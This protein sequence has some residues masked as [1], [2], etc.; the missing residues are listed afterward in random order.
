MDCRNLKG[1]E[2]IKRWKQGENLEVA[3]ESKEYSNSLHLTSE[4]RGISEN[5]AGSG[6]S[7]QGG[8]VIKME[9]GFSR[10]RG[11]PHGV[12]SCYSGVGGLRGM[13]K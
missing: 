3:R 1:G 12:F 13:R 7:N 11:K 2:V 4:Q 10:A 9:S 6:M 5:A 8:A